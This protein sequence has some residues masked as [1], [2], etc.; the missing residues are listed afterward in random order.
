MKSQIAYPLNQSNQIFKHGCL[1]VLLKTV[2][3]LNIAENIVAVREF[4]N[5]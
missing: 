3:I 5:F 1:K 4:Q 2:M